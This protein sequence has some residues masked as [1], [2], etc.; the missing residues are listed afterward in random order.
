MTTDPSALTGVAFITGAGSGIG[1]A[2]ARAF[3]AKGVKRLA[4]VD[5]VPAGVEALAA[6]LKTAG[7]ETLA[8][9]ADMSQEADVKSAVERA[10]AAFGR[11]DYC[12]NSAGTAVVAPIV[13]TSIE[14]WNRVMGVNITGVFL[15][16][17]EQTLQMLK[18]DPLETDN[19]DPKR[20]Q[21]GSIVNLASV[22]GSVALP[23]APSYVASKHAV[24]GLAKSAAAEYAGQ[25]IRT[26]NIAPGWIDTA[27]TNNEAVGPVLEAMS[28]PEKTPAGRSGAAEEIADVIVFLSSTAASF[29]NGAT[30][31]VDGGFTSL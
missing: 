16:V 14:D 17:R 18:Q 6:E 3:L 25:G 4:L 5:Y 28:K 8:L 23:G 11:L 15:C 24:V 21:R 30:W 13:Q 10:V 27:M 31:V 29:T 7:A 26:N 2:T 20:Q 19:A 9:T 22:L 1:R 12:V